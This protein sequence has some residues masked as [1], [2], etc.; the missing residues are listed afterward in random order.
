MAYLDPSRHVSLVLLIFVAATTSGCGTRTTAG[1]TSLTMTEPGGST[2]S[3]QIT[4]SLESNKTTAMSGFP[5]QDAATIDFAGGKL[6]IERERVLL[7]DKELAA[8]PGNAKSVDIK[9]VSGS[10]TI[11]ADGSRVYEG[12]LPK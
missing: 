1:S 6:L 2:W 5:R 4:Y 10:L 8:V 9:C 7:N 3:R 12:K 11:T